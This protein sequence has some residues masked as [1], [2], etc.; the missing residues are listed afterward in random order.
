MVSRCGKETVTQEP[1]GGGKESNFSV[2]SFLSPA[3]HW[4]KFAQVV[5]PNGSGQPLGSECHSLG[6]ALDLSSA[7]V[8][9]PEACESWPAPDPSPADPLCLGP[10]L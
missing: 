4:S 6:M 1:Y 5:L 10:P 2:G 3:S 7:V 8:E 9:G